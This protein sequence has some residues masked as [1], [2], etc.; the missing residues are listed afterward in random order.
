LGIEL[1]RDY[2]NNP[3]NQAC[4]D[5]IIPELGYVEGNVMIIS[6][7]ANVIKN[8]ATADELI[9]IG[10]KLKALIEKAK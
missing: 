7:R 10:T 5:R 8:D 3:S 6:R 2:K 4:I 1:T 9:A